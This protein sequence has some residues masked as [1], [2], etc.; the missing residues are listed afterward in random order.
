MLKDIFVENGTHV[1]GFLAKK[2]HI[3]AAH[4]LTKCLNIQESPLPA[5]TP[6]MHILYVHPTDRFRKFLWIMLDSG[7]AHNLITPMT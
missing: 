4:P 2:Q 1:K 3:R 7:V 6:P 5:H